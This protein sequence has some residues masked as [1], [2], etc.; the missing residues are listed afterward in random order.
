MRFPVA[1]KAAGG[2]LPEFIL[3]GRE[4]VWDRHR[5]ITPG[6]GLVLI[7]SQNYYFIY[8]KKRFNPRY[9]HDHAPERT[10]TVRVGILVDTGKWAKLY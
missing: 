10:Q 2:S 9:P 8:A 3:A 1:E 4:D 5:F 7:D 6:F